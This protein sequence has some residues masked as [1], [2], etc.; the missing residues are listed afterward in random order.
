[1]SELI[2]QNVRT[3]HRVTL[4]EV[5]RETES[6]GRVEVDHLCSNGKYR[7]QI[8][9]D[10]KSG[11]MIYATGI[12]DDIVC[13]VSKAVDEARELGAGVAS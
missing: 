8:R 2:N 9:F 11:T 3:L 13:A 5:W 7:V 10:R 4:D 12:D 1:M 6:L